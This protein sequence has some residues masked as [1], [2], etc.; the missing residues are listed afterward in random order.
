MLSNMNLTAVRG[1]HHHDFRAT[2]VFVEIAS[3]SFGSIAV[4]NTTT[5]IAIQAVTRSQSRRWPSQKCL[6]LAQIH[7]NKS[8][9]RPELILALGPAR[10]KR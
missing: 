4:L 6:L 2:S 8:G 9:G 5:I 1:Y 3:N 10:D 7:V